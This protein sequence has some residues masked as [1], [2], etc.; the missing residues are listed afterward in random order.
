MR[1]IGDVHGHHDRY[2]RLL[3]GCD[4]SVQVGDF[5]FQYHILSNLDSDRHKIVPGNQDNNDIIPHFQHFL[6]TYGL[7][8]H[9][10]QEFFYVRGANS[11]DKAQR[12]IGVS[13]FEQEELT[14]G[15]LFGAVEAVIVASPS[16]VISHECPAEVIQ[17]VSRRTHWD[18][19]PLSPSK[20]A[21]AL[22]AMWER[23]QPARWLFGHHHR[24]FR[25]NIGGTEFICLNELEVLDL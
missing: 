8:R 25:Q 12:L 14:I 9:G 19:V 17:H 16:L 13:W 1:I 22:Q 11:I 24:S 20:T 7:V 10:G 21:K 15:Q 5:G 2:L 6:S 23:H 3:D 4:A 18:N